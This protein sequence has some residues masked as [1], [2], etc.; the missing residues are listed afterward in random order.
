MEET[1]SGIKFEEFE[2]IL[3]E[4][5]VSVIGGELSIKLV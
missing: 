3:E 4:L 1:G 2:G 5:E